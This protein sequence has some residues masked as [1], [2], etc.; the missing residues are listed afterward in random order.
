M[1]Y[2]RVAEEVSNPVLSINRDTGIVTA[3]VAFDYEMR[4]TYEY[5]VTASN[6][7]PAAPSTSGDGHRAARLSA[8]ATLVVRVRDADDEKPRFDRASYQFTVRENVAFGTPVGHVKATDGDATPRFNRIS[9]RIRDVNGDGDGVRPGSRI[10]FEVDRHTGQITTSGR[11]DREESAIFRFTVFASS[12]DADDE[13]AGDGNNAPGDSSASITIYIDDENDNAPVV[14]F[15]NHVVWVHPDYHRK[16]HQAATMAS[17][18]GCLITRIEATDP[19][20][21]E[22]ARLTYEISSTTSGGT[23]SKNLNSSSSNSVALSMFAIDSV[24]GVVTST[25]AFPFAALEDASGG[26]SNAPAT[27]SILVAVS[28]NGEPSRTSVADLTIRV[29]ISSVL[30]GRSRNPSKGEEVDD[31]P[32]KGTLSASIL[33]DE[34]LIILLGMICGVIVVTLVVTTLCCFFLLRRRSRRDRHK[35]NDGKCEYEGVPLSTCRDS[36]S[37]G[38]RSTSTLAMTAKGRAGSRMSSVSAAV[39]EQATDESTSCALDVDE[40]H[41]GCSNVDDSLEISDRASE[42]KRADLQYRRM[43]GVSVFELSTFLL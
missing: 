16:C 1:A 35:A 38:G 9:Y 37:N 33:S 21:G 20:D 17:G 15:P 28:D 32:V 42:L 36:A 6:H 3:N 43:L 7:A 12:V 39:K 14:R 40:W 10:P 4:T 23:G 25:E 19:D 18:T 31:E 34:R 41:N 11:I 8:T 26:D 5:L 27:Y 2:A 22:N 24:T 30:S 29:N 13:T